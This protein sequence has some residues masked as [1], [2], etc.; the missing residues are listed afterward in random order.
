[1]IGFFFGVLMTE[2]VWIIYSRRGKQHD[3][4]KLNRK[5]V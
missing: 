5:G 2:I 3:L 4:E 1:M